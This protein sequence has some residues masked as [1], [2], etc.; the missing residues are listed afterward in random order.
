MNLLVIG[1]GNE[2]RGDDGVGPAVARAVEGWALPGVSALASHGLTP[3]LAEPM[4]RAD[5]VVFVDARIS[6]DVE[7]T[8]LTPGPAPRLGHASEPC[9]LLT[10]AQ[11]IDGRAAS[12][13]LV[14]IPATALDFGEGLSGRAAEGMALALERI[15]ELAEVSATRV[16]L[17][18]G[19]RGR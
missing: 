8:E 10:L 6:N 18:S 1:Y 19:R 3:E 4:S 7:W 17:A 13:W 2:L 12:A 14:T 15:R 5:V 11:A 9:W 16:C